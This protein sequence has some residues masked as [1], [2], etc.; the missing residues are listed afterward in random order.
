MSITIG[1]NYQVRVRE[2]SGPNL[3]G[4]KDLEWES[5]P[6]ISEFKDQKNNQKFPFDSLQDLPHS[7][8]SVSLVKSYC[9]GKELLGEM[10]ATSKAPTDNFDNSEISPHKFSEQ[11]IFRKSP[12]GNQPGCLYELPVVQPQQ[13]PVHPRGP[14]GL[15]PKKISYSAEQLRTFSN[16]PSSKAL[17][18]PKPRDI[19]S[20]YIAELTDMMRDFQKLNLQPKQK[21]SPQQPPR[22]KNSDNGKEKSKDK[23]K[24]PPSKRQKG[25]IPSSNQGNTKLAE[26]KRLSSPLQVPLP[27]PPKDANVSPT[28]IAVTSP[29]VSEMEAEP[30]IQKAAHEDSARRL[31]TRQRQIDIG[32]A[33][34]GYQNYSKI[35]P[36]ER[37]K[38]TDPWTPNKNQ[39][40][41]KRSWDGQIRKWRREL[42]QWDPPGTPAPE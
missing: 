12:P 35:V 19:I 21:S 3:E 33:T 11:D 39:V 26:Q 40:C 22:K 30:P 41:S 32:K 25:E 10:V 1:E 15:R 14:P 18:N 13:L 24:T 16:S 8:F 28:P 9:E 29:T 27:N 37:R 20:K 36:K 34:A 7:A 17:P 4:G 6:K 2:L 23:L 5:K 42:H 38:R 31:E